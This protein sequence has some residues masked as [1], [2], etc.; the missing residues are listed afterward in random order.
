MKKI[1]NALIVFIIL[2]LI[3]SYSSISMAV[4]EKELNNEKNNINNQIEDKKKEIENIQAQKSEN[5]KAVETL[6]D[7]ISDYEDE[8]DELDGKISDLTSKIKEASNKIKED[9]EKYNQKQAQLKDILV[10]TYENGKTSFLDFLLSSNSLI[11]F[12]STYYMI[13]E[14]TSYDTDLLEEVEN[15][16]KSL[17]EQ[18]QTLEANK[19]SLNSAKTTKEAKSAA[20]KTAKTA[21]EKKVAELT[22]DEKKTQAEIQELKN[23]EASINKKIQQMK[24]EYDRKMNSGSNK[25]PTSLSSGWPVANPSIGTKYGVSGKYW[26]SG[27][28]TGV[29]F[30]ASIGTPVYSI[31][32]G[33]VF[34]TG[35]NS[36][37]G[38]YVEIYHGNNIYSFYAHASSVKVKEGQTVSKGQQIMLSGATGNVTGP[39]LHFEIR[40][41]GYRYSNC[42]NPMSYLP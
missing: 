12:I 16:K 6:M 9:E 27:Y 5:M 13:S 4:T 8:I 32:D 11:E 18:K 14:L 17:E 39:H 38:N 22:E 1:L 26:S 42:V 21:K 15:E 37:Y 29:D 30:K 20:L 40:T 23:H 28:H 7:Q 25:G 34:D 10:T 35:Y 24:E 33:Q 31:G 41:P 19:S 2:I 3:I 36:A